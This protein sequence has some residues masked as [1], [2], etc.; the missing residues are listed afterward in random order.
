M[1]THR[2]LGLALVAGLAL[3]PAA[4]GSADEAPAPPATE[5]PAPEEA[6]PATD[7]PGSIVDV[8]AAAGTFETLIA[9]A[10]AAGLAETLDTG[11]PFTVFAP[12][13]EAFAALPEGTL[14][15]LLADPDALAQILL[16]HVLAGEVRA[17]QVVELSEAETLQGETVSIMAHDGMVMINNATVIAADVE[18]SNGV[19]HVI[20]TVLLPGG[21]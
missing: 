20:D 10:S 15:G 18:A 2:L 19:I 13:D 8:A 17:A 14:E 7:A 5:V 4:C 9:A 3:V 21:N 1:F 12:T 16:Y 6:A 11:G